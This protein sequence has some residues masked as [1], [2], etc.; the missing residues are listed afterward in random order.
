MNKNEP[1]LGALK[2]NAF[3][4]EAVLKNVS[5]DF[6][7]YVQDKSRFGLFTI[8]SKSLTAKEDKSICIYQNVFK[9]LLKTFFFVFTITL[10][11]KLM[12]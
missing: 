6:Y 1:T 10:F 7:F 12:V 2:K 5:T 4:F 9:L 3:I 8:N 11:I